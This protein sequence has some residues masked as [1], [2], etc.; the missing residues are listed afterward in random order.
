MKRNIT[1]PGSVSRLTRRG[2]AVVEF[3]IMGPVFLLL[4]LGVVELGY[5]LNS[6]N[7]LYGAV[8]EGG[9]LASQD[10][11]NTLPPGMTANQ[12]VIQDIKNMLTAA[13]IPGDQVT[14]TIEHADQPGV[15][16]DLEDEDN[17]MKY[18]TI[19]ALVDY[20]QVSTIPGKYLGGRQLRAAITFRMGRVSMS[21]S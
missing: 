14:V 21:A 19:T 3:A 6:S 15:E 4:T 12:K 17:Y 11:S 9:R 18:F 2:A 10:F 16:F 13:R 20:E 8:R 7:T 5:A 1:Q